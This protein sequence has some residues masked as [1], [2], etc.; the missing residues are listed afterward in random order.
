MS[1]GA[2]I[3]LSTDSKAVVS[4]CGPFRSLRIAAHANEYSHIGLIFPEHVTTEQACRVAAAINDLLGAPDDEDDADG[5]E[6]AE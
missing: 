6:A 3:H 5:A 4:D 2:T 1:I